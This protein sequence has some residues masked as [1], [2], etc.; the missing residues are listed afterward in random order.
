M[1]E[2]LL[3]NPQRPAASSALLLRHAACI[4]CWLGLQACDSEPPAD[5]AAAAAGAM[6]R[7]GIEATSG[8]PADAPKADREASPP[9]KPPASGAGAAAPRG[10]TGAGTAAREPAEMPPKAAPDAETDAGATQDDRDTRWDEPYTGM[11]T[12]DSKWLCRPGLPNNPCDA[13]YR[14]TD[15][16]ADGTRSVSELPF[17]P[18][19]VAADCFY[20]YPTVDTGLFAA[21]RN[22]DFP[23]IDIPTVLDVMTSQALPFRPL[24]RVF[25][26]VYR[27]TSLVSF[28]TGGEAREAGLEKGYA[29]IQDAFDYFLRNSS[30]RRPLVLLAHSQGTMVTLRLITRHIQDDP[31]LRKRLV[32]AVLAGPLGGFSVPRGALMGASLKDIPLCSSQRQTGCALTYASF[33]D[34]NPPNAD[35]AKIGGL[36]EPGQDT[37]C[38]NPPKYDGDVIRSAGALFV[39]RFRQTALSVQLNVKVDTDFARFGD[40]FTAQCKPSKEDLSY[41][42]IAVAP[43]EGDKRQNPVPFEALALSDASIGLHALDY[44]FIAAELFEAVKAKIEAHTGGQP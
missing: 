43:R 17:T 30:F 24:C 14:I 25:A 10:M 28:T 41:L 20:V 33:I 27:Q 34:K 11:Y 13:P 1:S 40:F 9:G 21:P 6:A 19:D 35:Y 12:D 3:P 29:D 39:T 16:H 36:V 4:L 23:Q 15:F 2:P 26:P 38:T 42:E 32:V 37:G 31:L 8:G 18:K 5:A 44:G 7:N 22:L